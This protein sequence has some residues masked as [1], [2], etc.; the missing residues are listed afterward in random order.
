MSANAEQ[1]WRLQWALKILL[2]E[3]QLDPDTKF[4]HRLGEDADGKHGKVRVHNFEINTSAENAEDG[5][6]EQ[7][8]TSL[9]KMEEKNK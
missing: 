7:A 8:V 1:Q 2:A 6:L 9:L 4:K 3:A 5:S